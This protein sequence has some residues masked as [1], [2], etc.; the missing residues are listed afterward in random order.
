MNCLLA[1]GPPGPSDCGTLPFAKESRVRSMSLKSVFAAMLTVLPVIHVSADLVQAEPAAPR[2]P[3]ME[4]QELG[5]DESVSARAEDASALILTLYQS[6]VAQI[7]ERREFGMQR[8]R[9]LLDWHDVPAEM[10]PQTLQVTGEGEV[11][12]H[13]VR[14]RDRVLSRDTLLEASVGQ[15][16]R[17]VRGDGESRRGRL[18]TVAG[19]TPVVELD[20]G[21][22]LIDDGNPWRIAL[23]ALP[24]GLAGAPVLQLDLSSD[25]PGR[26]WLDLGYLAEGLA[27]RLDYVLTIAP[28]ADTMELHAWATLRNDTDVDFRDADV[29]L[30][31]GASDAQQPRLETLATRTSGDDIGDQGEAVADQQRFR[32]ERPV[33]LAAGDRRQLRFLQ[34]DGI[35][36]EREYRVGSQVGLGSQSRTQR[37]PVAIQMAFDNDESVLGRPLPAGAVRIYQDDADGHAVYTGEERLGA[38]PVGERAELRPGNAFDLTA[39]RR[40][41]DYRRLDDNTEEQ[42]WR[43]TLRNAGDSERTVT[44]EESLPGEWTMLD[45]SAGHSRPDAGRAR[46]EVDV[47]AE[48]EAVLEYRVEIRR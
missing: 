43:V 3:V 31:A 29:R 23:D 11:D 9:V 2:E 26:Q 37:R 42:A 4:M 12:V 41:T 21:I 36:V 24:P 5:G 34:A 15:D 13:E 46:W 44:V 10:Q 6:G 35:P 48:G 47:P 18:L 25:M 28:E 30:V 17:L 1:V 14:L 19:G 40:Q 39:E 16:V 7:A 45:E 8:G 22:E 38:T 33:T 27:W 20:D 32:L